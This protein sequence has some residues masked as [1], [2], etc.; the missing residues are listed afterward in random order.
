M[1]PWGLHEYWNWTCLEMEQVNIAKLVYTWVL[2]V[3]SSF[4]ICT[5]MCF[6]PHTTS[7]ESHWTLIPLVLMMSVWE[8]CF[9]HPACSRC[10]FQR[11]ISERQTQ[12]HREM[13]FYMSKYRTCP[14]VFKLPIG[15]TSSNESFS[16]WFLQVF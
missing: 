10:Y 2:L 6:Y 11:Y 9:L 3:S 8:S 12:R 5:F 1:K 4:D 14:C 7:Q 13:Q 16:L 15:Q